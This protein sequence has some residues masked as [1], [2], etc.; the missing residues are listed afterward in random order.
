MLDILGG[1]LDWNGLDCCC[2]SSSS[3]S[4]RCFPFSAS[5]CQAIVAKISA[6]VIGKNVVELNIW[7][8]IHL[9]SLMRVLL[10]IFR[11]DFVRSL[12]FFVVLM[13]W[14]FEWLSLWH[15]LYCGVVIKNGISLPLFHMIGLRRLRELLNKSQSSQSII[16]KLW[17]QQPCYLFSR[18]P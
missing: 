7:I 10:I 17:A 15:S 13:C 4:K 6:S 16:W 12:P 9:S 8:K 2:L 14:S 1:T 11:F 18:L 5:S 3:F